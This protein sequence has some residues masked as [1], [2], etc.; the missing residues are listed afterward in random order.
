MQQAVGT[1]PDH[2]NSQISSL[3]WFSKQFSTTMDAAGSIVGVISL[4]ITLCDG[5]LTYCRAW[6]HQDD[7]VRSL[8]ALTEGLRLLLQD[9]ERKVK[10]NPALDP[11][12]VDRLNG[13]IQA[14]EEHV[15]AVLQLS[16]E[17]NSVKPTGWMGMMKY[18][19]QKL[20]FPFEKK[21]LEELRTIML[22]FRGNVTTAMMLLAL[23]VLYLSESTSA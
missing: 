20:K 14:C 21:M 13:T 2:H 12:I 15:C 11:A 22:A 19:K 23:C 5:I 3:P 1:Q 6:R 7:E 17:Y 16:G 18:L 10:N 4:G 8:T 9:V